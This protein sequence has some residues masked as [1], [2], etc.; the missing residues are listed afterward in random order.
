MKR[1][2]AA[3]ESRIMKNTPA[4]KESRTMKNNPATKESKSMKK[5]VLHGS[6]TVEA[7]FVFPIIIF[8]A[9]A[10]V[11]LCIYEYDRAAASA[12]AILILEE[13]AAQMD[14]A[15][16]EDITEQQQALIVSRYCEGYL[17]ADVIESEAI[18]TDKAI[19][20]RL[21]LE[22]AVPLQGPISAYTDKFRFI[23]VEKTH[24]RMRRER[25]LRI[26][27]IFTDVIDNGG[28]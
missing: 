2:L 20:V 6:A 5:T 16:P 27:D 3:K 10:V 22:V 19:T 23:T 1:N 12:D 11:W 26:L 9:V 13:L 15:S 18:C 4:T 24:S 28:T 21:K 14:M 25:K 8:S 7:A 17:S